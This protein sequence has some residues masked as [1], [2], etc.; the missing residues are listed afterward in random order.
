VT[1]IV[2]I[3]EGHGEVEALPILIRRIAMSIAP[4]EVPELPKPIRVGRQKF[5]KPDELERAVELAARNAGP[6]GKILIL[7]DADEDCPGTLG[8]EILARARAARA[9]RSISVVLAKREFESWFLAAARSIAGHRGIREDVVPPQDPEEVRDPKRWLS[10]RMATGRPYRETLDQPALSTSFDLEAG[11][12]ASSFDKM[13]REL[14]S[15]L[16]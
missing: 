7:L 5:L 4:G 8:P 10:D 14:A 11:R 15:A 3:V 1:K 13:W 2:T 16:Q 12:T 6:N 9:D